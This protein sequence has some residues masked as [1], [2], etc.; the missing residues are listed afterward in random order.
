MKKKINTFDLESQD[1]AIGYT[2]KNEPFWFDKDDIDLVKKYSW[3]YNTGGYVVHRGEDEVIYLHRLVMGVTDPKIQVDHIRHPP[4]PQH[5][6]DNRKENLRLV[7][8][9]QNQ[10]NNAPSKNN[11]S[12]KT[13]V[14]WDKSRMKWEAYIW[15][16]RKKVHLGRFANRDEAID[17]RKKA[18]KKY[19]GEY[20]YNDHTEVEAV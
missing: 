5:K 7:T 10:M 13:G 1:Y 18:E 8:N 6:I 2:S 16:N 19:F 11:T 14:S 17:A 12:G 9:Q 20:C 15:V 4:K 3:Y